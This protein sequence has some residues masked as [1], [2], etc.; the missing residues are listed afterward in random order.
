M[1]QPIRHYVWQGTRSR[2]GDLFGYARKSNMRQRVSQFPHGHFSKTQSEMIK[3]HKQV[4]QKGDQP[5]TSE[6]NTAKY[7]VFE[8]GWHVLLEPATEKPNDRFHS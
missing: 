4:I 3:L 2:H 8:T 1:A 7:T 5:Q 6:T